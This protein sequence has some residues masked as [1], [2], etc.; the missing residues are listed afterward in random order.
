MIGYSCLLCVM[1]C[2]KLEVSDKPNDGGMAMAVSG[3]L[4]GSVTLVGGPCDGE[5]VPAF[6]FRIHIPLASGERARIGEPVEEVAVY[7]LSA[8]GNRA[9]FTEATK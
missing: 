4:T 1:T 3:E 9:Y 6:S 7:E 5:S 8:T 2:L